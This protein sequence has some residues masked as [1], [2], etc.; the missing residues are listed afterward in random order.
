VR[1][2]VN[3]DDLS[4][5]VTFHYDVEE[6]LGRRSVEQVVVV[7][8]RNVDAT[9]IAGVGMNDVVVA[10]WERRIDRSDEKIEDVAV[11]D[12][13]HTQHVRPCASVHLPDH[14][15]ELGDLPITPRRRPAG[16][17]FPDRALQLLRPKR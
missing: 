16:K 4:G 12:L 11:L 10:V 5:C 9:S 15:G 7:D 14:R 2:E 8:E 17:V 13:A 3:L 1:L 6:H